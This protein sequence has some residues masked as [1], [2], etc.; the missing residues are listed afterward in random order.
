MRPVAHERAAR[1]LAVAATLGIALLIAHQLRTPSHDER[2]EWVAIT[3]PL[4]TPIH[5]WQWIVIHHSGYRS[6]DTA[7]I[8]ASHVHDRKWD[9]IGYH[10]VVGNGSPM[11]RGRVDATW[12]WKAQQHGA[13]AGSGA[14]QSAYNRDGIGIC[15]I[16]N[17]DE[18]TLD[19]VVERR[20]TE[21][22]AVLV[23]RCPAL[24]PSRIVG[25]RDVPGKETA[26][27]G[28][29]IDIGR[30]RFQVRDELRRRG[31]DKE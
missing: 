11:P 13:H 31:V 7:S 24:S 6:G 18:Q 26:C 25:H 28:R 20:L 8:D 16:G 29:A 22:C 10:F 4:D 21:L 23:E 15:L 30:L 9:G 19:A 2:V 17:Y 14:Q 1:V 12:R 5:P 27:P 3:P